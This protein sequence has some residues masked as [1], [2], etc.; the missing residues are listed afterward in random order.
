MAT[1]SNVKAERFWPPVPEHIWDRIRKQFTPPDR[2]QSSPC[3]SRRSVSTPCSG[4]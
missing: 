2:P 1:A 4:P 3:A